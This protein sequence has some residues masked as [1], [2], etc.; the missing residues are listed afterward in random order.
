MKK[1][2]IATILAT[3]GFAPVHAEEG[4]LDRSQWTWSTSSDCAP[5][6]N[7]IVGLNGICDDDPYT[8]WH[9]NFHADNS[10]P[11][12]KNPHWVMIDRGTDKSEFTALSYLPRQ[13]NQNTACTEYAIYLSDKDLGNTPATDIYDIY[14]ALGDPDISG[15]WDA[16][17][18]EQFATLKSPS[19]A[20]YI[21]FVNVSSKSSSSAACA[22]MN[23]IGEGGSGGS[24]PPAPSAYNSIRIVPKQGD[25]H[26]IAIDGNNLAISWTG[27]AVRM[28][29]SRITVE[30]DLDEVRHLIPEKYD[31]T[32]VET[33]YT[34]PKTDIYDLPALE[35][36]IL[37]QTSLT[38]IEGESA[39]LTATLNPAD[40]Q[41]DPIA[42]STSNAAVATVDDGLITAI[43]PG[44]AVISAKTGGIEASCTVTV[45]Q[46][47]AEVGIDSATIPTLT[48]GMDGNILTVKRITSGS[49][50][51]LT[52]LSG[53][54]V[55]STAVHDTT[56]IFN[57]SHLQRG[58]YLLTASGITVKIIL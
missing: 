54:K 39:T 25:E 21:L 55:A 13:S 9:S 51:S 41:A 23:L 29:N 53:I 43:A 27:S 52:S 56:A 2:I 19:E 20:R 40:A 34:G 5:D 11:Q 50:A 44:T 18:N 24:N 58:A 28:G 49:T 12:R 45:N 14:A 26:R 22:E 42:W 1:I 48:L 38:L 33:L 8:V 3:A 47:P 36:I 7:D 32:G 15:Y 35:G 30:Y 10:S 17:A 37:S 4:Y 6:G 31:F 46:K 57:T 16:S